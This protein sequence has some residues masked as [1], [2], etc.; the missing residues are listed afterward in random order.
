MIKSFEFVLIGCL[1][2]LSAFLSASEVALF[3]LSRFQLRYLKEHFR[4]IYI[5]IK[6]LISD[7]SGL[8]VTILVSNEIVNI[9]MATIIEKIV[10]RSWPDMDPDSLLGWLR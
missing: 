4:P 9:S 3:S 2:F 5:Q 8:L 6:R 7:P 10:L 1:V